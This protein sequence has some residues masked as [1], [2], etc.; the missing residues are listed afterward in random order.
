M[1]YRLWNDDDYVWFRETYDSITEA[2]KSAYRRKC[3]E[4]YVCA[5]NPKSRRDPSGNKK[6]YM[7]GIVMSK[8]YNMYGVPIYISHA[9]KDGATY[10]L[11][12]DGTLGRKLD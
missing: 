2:R 7:I 11:N 5:H 8:R 3:D 6:W 4:T 9:G 10:I 12:S 1:E